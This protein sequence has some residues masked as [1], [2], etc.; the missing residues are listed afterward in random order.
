MKLVGLFLLQ[1][2]ISDRTAW[3]TEGDVLVAPLLTLQSVLYSPSGGCRVLVA[4]KL[5]GKA[6]TF[7]QAGHW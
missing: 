2:R 3:G 1:G 7:F 6:E 4:Q 5:R